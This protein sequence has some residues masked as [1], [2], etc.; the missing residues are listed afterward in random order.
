MAPRLTA[1][2]AGLPFPQVAARYLVEEPAGSGRYKLREAYASEQA[3][4]AIK[5]GKQCNCMAIDYYHRRAAAWAF[6]CFGKKCCMLLLLLPADGPPAPHPLLPPT[7]S[8]STHPTS[9]TPSP[10]PQVR[11]DS[12]QWLLDEVAATKAGLLALRQVG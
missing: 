10:Y 8:R 11:P 5:V 12:P 1:F 2:L 3:I 6:L 4:A 7:P 9:P